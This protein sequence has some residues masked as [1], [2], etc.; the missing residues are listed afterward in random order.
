VQFLVQALI[1]LCVGAAL[2]PVLARPLRRVLL[3]LCGTEERA[4]FWS[5]YTW[6]LLVL[7]PLLFAL[8][9]NGGPQGSPL[10]SEMLQNTLKSALI[11]A[12]AALVAVGVMIAR[13]MRGDVDLR[14]SATARSFGAGTRPDQANGA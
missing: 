5:R 3:D 13:V 12:L 8:L 4:D 10:G 11:G 7:A 9:S 6:T 2:M 14:G 1:G